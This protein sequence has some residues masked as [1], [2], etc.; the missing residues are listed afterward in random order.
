MFLLGKLIWE[1]WELEAVSLC[2]FGGTIFF[3]FY[4]GGWGAVV[5]PNFHL[6][7]QKCCIFCIKIGSTY[8]KFRPALVLLIQ[9]LL[10]FYIKFQGCHVL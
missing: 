2:V 7:L 3:P 5:I 9:G 8:S 1:G 4:L 6:Y 10:E